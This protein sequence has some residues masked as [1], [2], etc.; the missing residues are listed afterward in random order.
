MDL[1]NF[2]KRV[3][4]AEESSELISDIAFTYLFD[5]IIAFEYSPGSNINESI[6]AEELGISRTPIQKAIEKLV[7]MNLISKV[8][9][10]KAVIMPVSY[11]DCKSICDFRI[12]I[13]GEAAR[14]AAKYATPT[15]FMYLKDN[16]ASMRQKF[17]KCEYPI[18]EDQ[19]FHEKIIL[20]S[21]NPYIIRAYDSYKYK[22]LRYRTFLKHALF[23]S[24]PETMSYVNSSHTGIYNAIKNRLSSVARDEMIYDLQNM[25][26]VLHI[27]K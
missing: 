3:E 5:K 15:D 2:R 22:V 6:L 9:Q 1:D 14:L 11:E 25:N 19:L 7:S 26:D 12:I 10:K 4:N 21:K 8:S 18:F 16:L 23:A 24:S 20:M 27:L 13:E 17:A